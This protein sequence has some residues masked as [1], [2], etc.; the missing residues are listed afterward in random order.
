MF[1]VFFGLIAHSAFTINW[2]LHDVPLMI[3]HVG[4]L[5]LN[6]VFFSLGLCYIITPGIFLYLLM[7]FHGPGRSFHALFYSHFQCWTLVES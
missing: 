1:H 7:V 2:L 3:M 4:L 5:L 6:S